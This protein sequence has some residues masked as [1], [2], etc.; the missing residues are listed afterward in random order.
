MLD[1][2]RYDEDGYHLIRGLIDPATAQ[3]LIREQERF[4][5]PN[6][7]LS[8]ALQL[9]HRSAVIRN[10]AT[11]GPQI[12]LA[13]DLL[14][15]DVCFTHQ[16]FITK[17]AGAGDASDVPW[18]QDSGYGRLKPPSDLTVWIALCDTDESNGCLW[19]LPGSQHPGLVD[20]ASTGSLMGAQV[21]DRG[22]P[23]PMA[24]G[25]ALLFSG[26]LMHRSLPNR[27]SVARHAMYL[28]Y[29]TPD[30]IMVNAGNKPVLEDGFS[31]MVAGESQ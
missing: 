23:I 19:V 13:V 28:R 27:T 29:C 5:H 30:V 4:A 18:H 20:H 21:S 24:C 17:A 1:R 3:V 12:A 31:W 22:I 7:G 16:Q 25:D 14:G 26:H 8:V 10:F 11:S 9:V 2:S 6:T 15:P